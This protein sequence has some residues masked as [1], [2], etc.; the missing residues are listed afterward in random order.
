MIHT[1]SPE[2]N[3]LAVKAQVLLLTMIHELSRVPFDMERIRAI[4]P[5]FEDLELIYEKSKEIT[6]TKPSVG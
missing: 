3:K 1:P 2:E 4:K 6:S 5:F